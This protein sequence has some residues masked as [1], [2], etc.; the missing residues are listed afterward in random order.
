MKIKYIPQKMKNKK[1]KYH[2]NISIWTICNPKFISI[3]YIIVIFFIS[4]QFHR[5][6]IW[7]SLRLWHRKGSNMLT[8]TQFREI[9]IFLLLCSISMDLI[10]AE[11]RMCSIWESNRSRNPRHFFHDYTM[12]QIAT[13]RP[14]IFRFASD[15][16]SSNLTQLFPEFLERT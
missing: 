11:I 2:K 9:L 3:Q 12:V 7:A 6:N 8:G 4:S 14:T 10:Y 16:V 5:N 1:R 13:V 15:T